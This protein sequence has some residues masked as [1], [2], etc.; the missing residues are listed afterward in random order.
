MNDRIWPLAIGLGLL[1]VVLVNAG[2][3]WVAV[4]HPAIVEPS[5]SEAGAR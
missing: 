1:L 2:F 3:V 5:Y 4:T